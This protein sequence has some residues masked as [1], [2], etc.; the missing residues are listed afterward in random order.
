MNR[1]GLDEMPR[2][3]APST[4]ISLRMH[5]S[6]AGDADAQPE[7]FHLEM[8]RCLNKV[9]PCPRGQERGF[10][11][12]ARASMG[13][14]RCPI[15]LVRALARMVRALIALAQPEAREDEGKDDERGAIA[16]DV[17]CGGS[18]SQERFSGC[19]PG[20]FPVWTE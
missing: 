8:N 17:A 9:K 13:L 15:W 2:M 19:M 10:E 20:Y 4:L 5:M 1:S 18:R 12:L 7:R 3:G 16:G 6:Y 11:G 14:I